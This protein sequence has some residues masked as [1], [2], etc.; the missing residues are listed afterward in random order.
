LKIAVHALSHIWP[1]ERR[2]PEASFGK[3]WD[4]VVA[5]FKWGM[6]RCAVAVEV[7][8]FPLGTITWTA[9]LEGETARWGKWWLFWWKC[10]VAP[11]SAL[12]LRKGGVDNELQESKVSDD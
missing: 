1:T 9:G 6:G 2:D 12:K 4:F 11:L 10:A 3:A 8:M 7:M 5:G